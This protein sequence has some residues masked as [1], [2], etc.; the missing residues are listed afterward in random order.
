MEPGS[1]VPLQGDWNVVIKSIGS[2]GIAALV[3]LRRATQLPEQLL[4]ARLFQAP[5]I[6]LGGLSQQLAQDVCT[7]LERGGLEAQP[8]HRDIAVAQ[9]DSE[10]EVALVVR[11][12]SQMPQILQSIV[13][14]LGC[15]PIV[16]RDLLCA[17]P[18][19]IVGK[20]S[21]QTA[22]AIRARF[23][24]LG[25]EVDISHTSQSRYDV[26][27]IDA[28]IGERTRLIAQA[29]SRGLLKSSPHEDALPRG[30]LAL[31]LSLREAEQIFSSWAASLRGLQVLNR[32]LLRFDLRLDR[33]TPSAALTRFLVETA[34][35]PERAIAKILASAPIITHSHIRWPEKDRLLRTYQ[36]LGCQAS[37]HLLAL[38]RFHVLLEKIDNVANSE[39]ILQAIGGLSA[40]AAA[41]LCRGPAIGGDAQAHGPDVSFSLTRARWIQHELKQIG[42]VAKVVART[43]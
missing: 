35:M 14:L 19:R 15:T 27:C 38:Q 39:Q 22:L 12:A 7:A 20:I 5:Q 1:D 18:A 13:S 33:A 36:E 6:L 16:A 32:D 25:A 29:R 34:R 9:G 40:P 30:A 8:S 41:A 24:R 31:D 28:P 43:E 26:Y 10:H 2:G 23:E 3:A 42:T 21:A 11:S 17:M 37:A 4:A